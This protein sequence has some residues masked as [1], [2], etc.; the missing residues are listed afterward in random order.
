MP[1][2]SRKAPLIGAGAATRQTK[3]TLK[4]LNILSTPVPSSM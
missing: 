3:S 4:N 2:L 1:N